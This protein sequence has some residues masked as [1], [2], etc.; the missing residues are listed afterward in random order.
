MS[1]TNRQ[2]DDAVEREMADTAYAIANRS[3]NSPGYVLSRL[4]QM[5]G[6]SR[7]GV[8]IKKGAEV[9]G[10]PSL[11]LRDET[12]RARGA[13]KGAPG[14]NDA[15]VVVQLYNPGEG[16]WAGYLVEIDGNNGVWVVAMG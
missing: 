6:N 11:H 16:E 7:W 15:G 12:S 13:A 9:G 4:H 14:P 3:N 2:M 8:P 10:A 5:Y 1:F